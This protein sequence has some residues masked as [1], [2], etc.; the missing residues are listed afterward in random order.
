MGVLRE[1]ATTCGLVVAGLVCVSMMQQHA[2]ADEDGAVSRGLPEQELHRRRLA[3]A[4]EYDQATRTISEIFNETASTSANGMPGAVQLFV[5]TGLVLVLGSLAAGA[6]IGGGGLFVPIY[7]ALLGAGPKGAVPLSKATILGGAI[8]NFI[9]LGFARHP[10]AKTHRQADRPMIDYEAST[11]MQSGELLG[12]VFGVLLNNL[13]P[14]ICIV[15]FLVF[16]LSFNAFKT[17]KKGIAIRKKETAAMLK[18][19]GEPPA[20]TT[21]TTTADAAAAAP[22]VRTTP[23]EKEIVGDDKASAAADGSDDAL[24]AKDVNGVEAVEVKVTVEEGGKA[25]RTSTELQAIL[26]DNAKQ[27]PVWAWSLLAPM[28][29]FTVVYAIVKK[30]IKDSEGCVEAGYW[31][32]YLTP[33]PVLGG[34]MLGTAYILK[35]RH[36]RKV[37]A[38]FEYL[39]AD[40]QWD[41]ETLKRFP[42][43]AILAGVTAGLLGIGGGMVIG[44]LFLSIG[45]EPQVGT[46]SCAFMILWTAFSGV[47]IYG[48]DG[49]LGAELAIWCVGFG[50]ISGQI[51]QRL[52]NAV[53]KKTGR[54]SYVVFLLGSIIGAA[55][56]AMTCMMVVKMVTGDYDA[57]DEVEDDE[58]ISTHLFY[59]GSGFGCASDDHYNAT[60]ASYAH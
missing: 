31:L 2:L 10:K 16:I 41:T 17:L 44:P 37:A 27:Y 58:K 30:Q 51:G 59:L 60:N 45:M 3:A 22:A 32:W 55:C 42:K 39:A 14:A 1:L 57:N 53:L 47:V 35:N 52:V 5:S 23:V 46:S 19:A 7:M 9:S 38:G 20:S 43:T 21:T 4:G 25:R 40:M 33:L 26:D 56:V 8:G 49:K 18:A 36:L 29:L 11:F 34:F 48:V 24:E 12:V 28:T 6:G 54:P 15:V 13:L 50:F